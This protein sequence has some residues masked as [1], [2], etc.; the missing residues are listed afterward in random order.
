MPSCE[1]L[2]GFYYE[3]H[4]DVV[5]MVI[6]KIYNAYK[7]NYF[8]IVIKLVS[9]TRLGNLLHRRNREFCICRP[10]FASAWSIVLIF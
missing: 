5:D 1:L 10:R 3:R 6:H 8:E 4:C 9:S 2:T 7:I